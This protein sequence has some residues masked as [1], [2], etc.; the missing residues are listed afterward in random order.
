MTKKSFIDFLKDNE[1]E[2][3][4]SLGQFENALAEIRSRAAMYAATMASKPAIK[5]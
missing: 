3:D 1:P 2:S 5:L 4:N